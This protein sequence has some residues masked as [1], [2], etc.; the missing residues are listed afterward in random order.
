MFVG[1]VLEICTG[2]VLGAGAASRISR[3]HTGSDLGISIVATTPFGLLSVPAVSKRVHFRD[4]FHRSQESRTGGC[5]PPADNGP[6]SATQK[7]S[8]LVTSANCVRNSGV[9]VLSHDRAWP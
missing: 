1:E 8:T 2:D 9:V 5:A 3:R 7:G 4:N 6:S